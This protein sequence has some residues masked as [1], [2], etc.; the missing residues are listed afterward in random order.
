MSTEIVK[1]IETILGKYLSPEKNRAFIFGSRATGKFA[2]FSDVDIGIEGTPLTGETYFNL[3]AAFDESDLPF[4]VDLVEF[5]DV[6]ER[7]QAVAKDKIVS[8]KL[9]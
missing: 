4:K 2:K 3:V 1:Q 9:K 7:F 5:N 6:S 8:L